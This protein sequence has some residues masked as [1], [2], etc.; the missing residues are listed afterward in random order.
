M[1]TTQAK[2]VLLYST[3]AGTCNVNVVWSWV[4]DISGSSRSDNSDP[5]TLQLTTPVLTVQMKVAVDPSVALTDVGM[6]VISK[7][8]NKVTN[9]S[10]Q[11]VH[12][13]EKQYHNF[14]KMS[15]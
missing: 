1:A 15:S 3:V 7:L 9:Y 6:L 4:F 14:D 8:G 2:T 12:V 5:L 13:T 11:N 10:Y